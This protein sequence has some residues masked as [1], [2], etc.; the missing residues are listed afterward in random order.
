VEYKYRRFDEGGTLTN[1]S[2]DDG[3]IRI[4]RN[5]GLI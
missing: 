5:C 2:I 4:L 3:G 1:A